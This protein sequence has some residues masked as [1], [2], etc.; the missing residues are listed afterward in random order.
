LGGYYKN[1]DYI[2]IVDDESD[3]RELFSEVL[4]NEG[5]NCLTAKD[6]NEVFKLLNLYEIKLIFLDIYL[7]SENGINIP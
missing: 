1:K 2:L 7:K 6:S 4:A 3:I 5:Y